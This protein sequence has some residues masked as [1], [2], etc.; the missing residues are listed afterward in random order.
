MGK[1]FQQ[2]QSLVW[3]VTLALAVMAYC[4]QSFATKEYVDRKHEGVMDAVKDIQVTTHQIQDQVFDLAR[5]SKR[6]RKDYK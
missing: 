2:F 3:A 5:G 6:D 4:Y 1:W